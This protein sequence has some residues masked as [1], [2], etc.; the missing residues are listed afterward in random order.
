MQLSMDANSQA[1]RLVVTI[2][3]KPKQ[4]GFGVMLTCL[5]RRGD[6][7]A[8]AGLQVEGWAVTDLL[9]GLLAE[10]AYGWLAGSPEDMVTIPA[11]AF[12]ARRKSIQRAGVWGI[13]P[14]GRRAVQE[15]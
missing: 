6:M 11:Q 8:S 4:A 7:L 5:S 13:T 10:V 12:R 15:D 1:H 3:D 2:T 9:P 14:E